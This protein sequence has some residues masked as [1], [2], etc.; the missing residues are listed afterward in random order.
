MAYQFMKFEVRDNVAWIMFNR[1]EAFNAINFQATREFYDIV[2]R[3]SVDTSIRA[4]VLTGTGERAFCAGGDVAEFVQK[5]DELE[6]MLTDPHAVAFAHPTNA[7]P[8][9]E[10]CSS[11][12]RRPCKRGWIL[13]PGRMRRPSPTTRNRSPWS[14]P[15]PRP[16]CRRTARG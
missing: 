9:L 15:R 12:A 14:T 2:N 3:C 7:V 5:G 6:L 1:P 4:V 16:L 10:S 8:I 13:P 11:T